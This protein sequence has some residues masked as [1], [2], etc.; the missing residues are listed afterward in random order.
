MKSPLSLST[1]LFILSYVC[2]VLANSISSSTSTST[3]SSTPKIC[4]LRNCN[5]SSTTNACARY[6]RS[7]LC[8]RFK[9]SCTLRYESCVGSATYTAV[10]LSQCSGISVGSRGICGGSSSSSSSSSSVTPIIIRRG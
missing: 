7:N 1:V 4:V 9:N 8:N 6:G 2:V 5:L 10:S 3:S